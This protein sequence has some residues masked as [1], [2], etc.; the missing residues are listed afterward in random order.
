ML[1]FVIGMFVGAA[2]G[3]IFAALFTA[4]KDIKER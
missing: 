4:A 1:N 3:F 2:C